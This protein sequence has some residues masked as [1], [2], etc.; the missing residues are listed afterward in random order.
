MKPSRKGVFDMACLTAT[1]LFDAYANAVMELFDATERLA[2]LVGQHGPFEE[3]RDRTE[4]AR[5]KCVAARL[6]LEQH[7]VQH[8]CRAFS[9]SVDQTS[10]SGHE[11][12]IGA[13]A[14]VGHVTSGGL[15]LK[16][17][18]MGD[19]DGKRLKALITRLRK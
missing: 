2:N 17:S 13:E 15:G 18:A 14:V 3:A 5:G 6:A 19:E 1:N 7:W 10:F 8:G 16:F 9:A 11:G 4:H 12:Q